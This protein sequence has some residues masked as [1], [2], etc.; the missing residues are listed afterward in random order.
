MPLSRSRSVAALLA[1]ALGA[2]PAAALETEHFARFVLQHGETIAQESPP[3]VF[4][5]ENPG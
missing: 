2:A 5:D 4:I 1:I 3:D